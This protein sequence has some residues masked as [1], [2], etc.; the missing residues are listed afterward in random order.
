[1]FSEFALDIELSEQGLFSFDSSDFSS[2]EGENMSRIRWREIR[3]TSL[4]RRAWSP[5]FVTFS[6]LSLVVLL[7]ITPAHVQ[8]LSGS[9]SSFFDRLSPND[10]LFLPQMGMATEVLLSMPGIVTM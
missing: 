10:S 2:K 6:V 5:S 3:F 9:G 8:A 1:M 7:F 4:Q